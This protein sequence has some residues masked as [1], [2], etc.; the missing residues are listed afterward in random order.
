MDIDFVLHS[1]QDSIQ[2]KFTWNYDFAD[3]VNDIYFI[4]RLSD[5]DFRHLCGNL[6]ELV[7]AHDAMN[8]ALEETSRDE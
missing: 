3:S 6:D 5:S 7:D 1:G 2:I 8:E 4:F